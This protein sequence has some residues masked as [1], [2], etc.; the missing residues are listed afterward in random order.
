[1]FRDSEKD[2]TRTTAR[3]LQTRPNARR[4]TLRHTRRLGRPD[5]NAI[6]KRPY[7]PKATSRLSLG[8]IR[9]H[10]G[11][12]AVEKTA[13][14]EPSIRK[15]A[16]RQT[17]ATVIQL[18]LARVFAGQVRLDPSERPSLNQD[19]DL[20]DAGSPSEK[21]APV[22][23]PPSAGPWANRVTYSRIVRPG[24]RPWAVG[25]PLWALTAGFPIWWALGLS[26]FVFPMAAIPM[27]FHLRRM[28][29]LRFPPLFW[30]WGLFLVWLMLSTVMLPFDPAYTRP[31]SVGGRL[32]SVGLNR[33][34][35]VAIT[36]T[37]LYVVNLPRS[38]V[39][40]A[41]V[42]R[43]LGV[44]FVVSVV[45]GFLGILAPKFS[46]TSPL[47]LLVP[48]H[49]RSDPYIASVVHPSA[50]QQQDVLG[51]TTG[52]PAAPFGYTNT[53]GNCVGVLLPFFAAGWICAQRRRLRWSGWVI[54]VASL[55]PI[56]YSLNRGLWIGLA[57]SALWVATTILIR[58]RPSVI[59]GLGFILAI[60]VVA[61]VATPLDTVIQT[62]INSP[63]NSNSNRAFLTDNAVRV[64]NQSPI[65]GWGGP[66]K[67]V[68]SGQSIAIGKT[69]SC[70]LC[71]DFSLGGNG[72]LWS[73]LI[74]VGW[75]GTLLFIGFFLACLYVYRR[76]RSPVAIA[77]Q[78]A[79]VGGF[80]YMLF[81][82]SI[83]TA[84]TLTMIGVGLLAREH[85]AAPRPTIPR[86][87]V[88][89]AAAVRLTAIR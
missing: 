19:R 40:N 39:S 61:F 38:A 24:R 70:P 51:D 22:S 45:G 43:W 41:R 64:A 47:E 56:V 10:R 78:V 25:W 31:G 7:R 65:I 36:V 54:G 68:G 52:R 66:R 69:S 30:L 80:V 76:Q 79:I 3:A 60:V 50:A 57:V 33:A 8:G 23:T 85:P 44:L 75:A 15:A 77:A 71:G 82:N 4:V 73:L 32:I 42:V 5:P 27:L 1:M 74:T 81:Y 67:T 35:W 17:G 29:P 16:R 86:N 11:T 55:V 6:A 26:V 58:G 88:R 59:I 49:L 62:R 48:S 20:R 28:R 18:P 9:K 63:N 37:L 34:E 83:P 46:F 89:T 14:V 72:Q 12:G 13:D 87:R 84:L 21:P 2:P 53:W